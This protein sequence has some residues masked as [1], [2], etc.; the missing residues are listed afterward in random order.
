MKFIKEIRGVRSGGGGGGGLVLSAYLC[1][2]KFLLTMPTFL[3]HAYFIYAFLLEN[4]H[5]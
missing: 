2:G 5:S 3:N 4:R 1:V